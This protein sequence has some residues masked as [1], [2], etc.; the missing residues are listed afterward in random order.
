MRYLIPMLFLLAACVPDIAAV[1]DGPAPSNR[2]GAHALAAYVGQPVTVLPAHGPWT[3]L[4]IIRPGMMI[5]QDYS[6]TRL[7]VRVGPGGRILEL[8]CG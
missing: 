4:R 5:T 7:N 6:A 8:F 2:C 1:S 3:T